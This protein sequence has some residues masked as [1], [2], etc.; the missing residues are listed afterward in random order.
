MYPQL[1]YT[2]W[3]VPLRDAILEHDERARLARLDQM[4]IRIRERLKIL[5][6]DG[7][8]EREQQALVDAL[9]TISIFKA[10]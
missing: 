7:A 1:R 8:H 4:E 9:A 10:A 2:E 3:Q 5:A 6:S